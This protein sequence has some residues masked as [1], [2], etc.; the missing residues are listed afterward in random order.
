MS[1][2]VHGF[3]VGAAIGDD[4]I[5]GVLTTDHPSSSYGLPVAVLGGQPY[6]PAELEG[7][8]LT[9]SATHEEG[10]LSEDARALYDAAVRVGYRIYVSGGAW[11]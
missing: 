4:P 11:L 6:G 10:A 1:I 3:L 9:V 2:K 8:C 5:E 7:A